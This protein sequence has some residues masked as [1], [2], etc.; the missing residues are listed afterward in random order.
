[1]PW[2]KAVK[3]SGN[4]EPRTSSLANNLAATPPFEEIPV[5]SSVAPASIWVVRPSGIA[6]S[7]GTIEC[8][9]PGNGGELI[10]FWGQQLFV[11]QNKSF[12]LLL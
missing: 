7:G 5:C 8:L 1:M 6:I 10:R 12:N 9:E 4:R 2:L 11:H 3:V